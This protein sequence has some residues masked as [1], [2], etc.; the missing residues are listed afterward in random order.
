[1][2]DAFI[3]ARRILKSRQYTSSVPPGT[4]FVGCQIN[5]LSN[6]HYYP[7]IYRVH[8]KSSALRYF[9]HNILLWSRGMEGRGRYRERETETK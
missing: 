4:E 8:W 2:S 7:T 5:N 1:M 3:P 6:L 9:H